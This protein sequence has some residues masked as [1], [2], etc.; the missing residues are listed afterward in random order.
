MRVAILGCGYIGLALARELLGD[1]HRVVGV[2][3]SEEGLSE[4]AEIGARSVHAD[5]TEPDTLE[6]IPAVDAIVFTASSGGADARGTRELV[7]DGLE[8]TLEHFAARSRTPDRVVYTSTT[9]VYGDHQG[10][11][12]NETGLLAPNSP[13]S[14]VYAEAELVCR[15]TAERLD[16]EPVIARLGGIYGQDRYRIERYLERPVVP[17]YRNLIHRQDVAGALRHFVTHGANGHRLVNVVDDE[18]VQRR[19]FVDWLATQVGVRP[20]PTADRE[21]LSSRSRSSLRRL[22]ASK[23]CDNTRLREI[24]YDLQ[25]PTFREGYARAVDAYCRT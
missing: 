22:T 17:G 3:R 24:G 11:W 6:A 9:G 1:D 23:R 7:V 8:A 18:P 12:V 15:E 21:S 13:K 20:P 14:A 4:V 10:A 25:Y 16:I 19:E 2:R 5:L